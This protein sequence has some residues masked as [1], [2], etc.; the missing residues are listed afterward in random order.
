M[1]T[2][3]CLSGSAIIKA[4]SK[5]STSILSGSLLGGDGTTFAVDEWIN[6]A[7]STVNGMC[8][9]DFTTEYVTLSDETKKLLEGITSD[10]V[11]IDCVC[12]DMSGYTT[13]TEAENIIN[14][15]RDSAQRGLSIIRDKKVQGFILRPTEGTA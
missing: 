5:V 6:Q 9:L 4:G 10:L 7:E 1:A 3:M 15:R 13:R 8:R 11:A 14:V 12:Y 2:T